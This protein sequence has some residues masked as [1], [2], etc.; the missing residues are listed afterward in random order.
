M[1]DS[2]AREVYGIK[3]ARSQDMSGL[4]FPYF[5]PETGYRATARLRRDNPETDENDKPKNKYISPYGDARHLYF[6]PGAAEKLKVKDVPIALVES[7]KAALALTAWAD[8]AGKILAVLGLGG[9]W[10]WRGRV[11]KTENPQGERVDV[12]GPLPDLSYCDAQ[13][14]FVVLDSNVAINHKVAQARAALV[15]DLLRRKCEVMVCDLPTVDGVNG[16]DD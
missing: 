16:P 3:A 15:A 5:S 13:K 1:T 11:G 9:C 12:K 10:G 8:R 7:E 4:V 6:P 2:E 14:V